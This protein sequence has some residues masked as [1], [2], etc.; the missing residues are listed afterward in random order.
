[1]RARMR[2]RVRV[3]V[4]LHADD[5]G[6][7][8]GEGEA[9]G[10]GE[11]EGEGVSL[12]EAARADAIPRLVT[13]LGHH[14]ALAPDP[15]LSAVEPEPTVALLLLEYPHAVTCVRLRPRLGL[16]LGLGLGLALAL[17]PRLSGQR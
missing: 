12:L 9:E 7:G 13:R 8:E 16:R 1:M 14:H 11:G 2:V 5:E 17:G 15:I 10:E 6:E 4:R 3:K